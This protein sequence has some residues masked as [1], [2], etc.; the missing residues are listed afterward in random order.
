MEVE[1]KENKDGREKQKIRM[2][3][4]NKRNKDGGRG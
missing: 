1:N 2:E 4:K 3:A